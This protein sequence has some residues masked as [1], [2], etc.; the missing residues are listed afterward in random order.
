M[1]FLSKIIE[2]GKIMKYIMSFLLLV[3][4]PVTF[5][6]CNDNSTN[7]NPSS[8]I[9]YE[10]CY[11][12]ASLPSS[13]EK[14]VDVFFVYPTIFG[15]TGEM[16]MDITDDNL[17][18]RVQTTLLKQASVFNKDCNVY[19][20]FYRQMA[21]DGLS[22]DEEIRNKYF[23]VGLND[24]KQAFTYY[25]NNLNNGRPFILAGHSQGSEVLINLMKDIFNDSELM[26]KLVAAYIIGFSVTNDD[27]AQY[28]WLK[29]A[30]SAD[31]IGAIITYNTQSVNATGS[32]VLLANANCVNPLNWLTTSEYAPKEKNLGA[33]FFKEN[34][35]IDSN[36]SHFTDAWIDENG[37]LVAG[38]ADVE[39]YS[40]PSFPKGVYHRY[41]YS[42]FY[43]N[44]IENVA[45][46]IESYLS[47]K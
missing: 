46:R 41:D 44:L 19:A 21:F 20:P 8:N 47:K 9:Y 2:T 28:K 39:V 17:R 31:E 25:I 33:V 16:N 32:P 34:G 40:S 27:L 42:F 4:L 14:E 6:S 30:E 12:W 24:V 45:V 11:N 5:T 43:N 15:G 23:V 10:D 22:M 13:I 7:S 29:I 38:N 37:A 1:I 26:D 36:V 3:V 35:E 18:I